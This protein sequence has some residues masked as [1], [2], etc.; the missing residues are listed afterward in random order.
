VNKDCITNT[1]SQFLANCG[2]NLAYAVHVGMHVFVDKYL[3]RLSW[4]LLWWLMISPSV[5]DFPAH[6]P[7]TSSYLLNLPLSPSITP[8]LS[9][10]AQDLPF[11]QIFPP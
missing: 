4:F 2:D 6:A 10:P 11:S 3:S 8:C 5:S 7:A 1:C 9:L